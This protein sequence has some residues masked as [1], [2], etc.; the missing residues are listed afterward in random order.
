MWLNIYL[1]LFL[2]LSADN[3]MGNCQTHIC[4][5]STVILS[6]GGGLKNRSLVNSNLSPA[7]LCSSPDTATAEVNVGTRT[8]GVVR[9]LPGQNPAHLDVRCVKSKS[10]GASFASETPYPLAQPGLSLLIHN[11]FLF[12][13][14]ISVKKSTFSKLHIVYLK[15]P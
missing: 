13:N 4:F 10:G 9:S 5:L 12:R 1:Y 8:D 15:Q 3:K 14:L 11:I 7:L 6:P 2:P